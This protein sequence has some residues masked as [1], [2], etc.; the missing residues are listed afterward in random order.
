MKKTLQTLLL[1]LLIDANCSSAIT[2]YNSTNTSES[3]KSSGVDGIVAAVV[4]AEAIENPT[5]ECYCLKENEQVLPDQIVETFQSLAGGDRFARSHP[6]YY[7]SSKELSPGAKAELDEIKQ[8]FYQKLS[9]VGYSP[10]EISVY[11]AA[12]T[13]PGGIVIKESVLREPVRSPNSLKPVLEHERIHYEF[14]KILQPE[15]EKIL[16]SKKLAP[17]SSCTKCLPDHYNSIRWLVLTLLK[18]DPIGCY[19]E[20][21]RI[22]REE[23]INLEKL[24]KECGHCQTSFIRILTKILELLEKTRLVKDSAEYLEAFH[25]GNR[26]IYKR[27]FRPDVV[28]NF[29]FTRIMSAIPHGAELLD[30][31]TVE[32]GYD[33]STVSILKLPNVNQPIYHLNPPEFALEEEFYGLIDLARNVLVE[34]RPKAEE[35]TDPQRTRQIFFNISRDLLQELAETKNIPLS[36][37]QLN[38]LATILVRHTIGFGLVEVLLQDENLQDIVLNSPI[39]QAPAFVRHQKF[40]ECSTNIIPSIEDADAFAANYSHYNTRQS[41]WAYLLN[42]SVCVANVSRFN[43]TNPCYIDT[44]NNKIWVRVPHFSGTGPSVI[45]STVATTAAVVTPGAASTPKTDGSLPA[46]EEGASTGTRIDFSTLTTIPMSVTEG[47]VFVLDFSGSYSEGNLGFHSIT[48]EKIMSDYI[49]LT[50]RSD[51]IIV[52]LKINEEKKVDINNDGVDDLSI[53]LK[54]I[55]NG[56]AD[57]VY[58]KLAGANKIAEEEIEISNITNE[59]RESSKTLWIWIGIIVLVILILIGVWYKVRV[60]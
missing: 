22:L 32:K 50:I 25:V 17:F 19:V 9:N 59:T 15:Q 11:L 57:L 10:E 28:P 37:R 16:S 31:Y 12:L 53:L 14:E 45:G 39:G 58:T 42:Q 46:V 21:K 4:A 18:Q 33:K 8:K 29:T 3:A 44:T 60:R 1:T 6:A 55:E 49:T 27:F 20:T 38:K 30:E 7:F 41:E 54:S 52:T 34:H 2:S 35:F 13:Q 40:D 43:I 47:Q 48:I 5:K 36:Y 56:K 26:E 23:K 51:P 24:P